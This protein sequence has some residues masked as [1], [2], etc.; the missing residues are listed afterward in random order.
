[1]IWNEIYE[2]QRLRYD[3]NNVR[4]RWPGTSDLAPG[5]AIAVSWDLGGDNHASVDPGR[6][7]K[8]KQDPGY[9]VCSRSR[10]PLA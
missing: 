6:D 3:E 8:A 9:A 10:N 1:M 4:T 7:T 2:A 5:R